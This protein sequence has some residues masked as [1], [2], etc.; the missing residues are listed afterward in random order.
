MIRKTW[1]V[2]VE[3]SVSQSTPEEIAQAFEIPMD[4]F[5]AVGKHVPSEEMLDQVFHQ[6]NVMVSD[7][8]DPNND[9]GI[10]REIMEY[11][12]IHFGM[13]VISKKALA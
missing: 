3:I 2:V 8:Y 7:G 6:L 5:H 9:N 10:S 4:E 12:G 13:K 11:L 1:Q